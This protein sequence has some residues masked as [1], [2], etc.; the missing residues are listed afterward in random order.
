MSRNPAPLPLIGQRWSRSWSARGES[1]S[2]I[3][4]PDLPEPKESEYPVLHATELPDLSTDWP[5]WKIFKMV[6]Y[7]LDFKVFT[8][9]LR[10]PRLS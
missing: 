4:F 5:K 2:L 8:S 3:L 7:C 6:S 1:P 9:P 10:S